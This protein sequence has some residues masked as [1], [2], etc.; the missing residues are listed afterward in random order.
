[1]LIFTSLFPNRAQPVHGIFIHQRVS[2]LGAREGN[3]VQVIAPVPYLPRWLRWT[4]WQTAVQVPAEEK[5]GGLVV[6]HPRYFLLPKVS[7]ILHGLLMFLGSWSLARRL[8]KQMDFDCIDAHYVYPDG[9]A[10]VLL[11]RRLGLPVVVSA[12]GTDINLFPTFRTIRPMIRWTLRHAAGI[13]AVSSSLRDAM[14]KLGAPAEKIAVIGNGV[15]VRRF[16]PVERGSARRALG[17]PETGPLIVSVGTLIPTKGHQ[18]LIEALAELAPRYP[19]LKAYVVGEGPY[20][21]QLEELAHAKG[22]QERVFLVGPKPN[23]D[24]KLWFSAADVSCLLSSREGWPNVLLETLAC[25]TP[26]VVTRVGGVPEV[27]CSPDLGVQVDPDV[28]SIAAGLELALRK[29]W[30]C[31]ALVRYAQARTWEVVGKE[32]ESYLG[33]VVDGLR[34]AKR[35]Y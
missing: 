24:L 1:V 17:L 21:A 3:T 31:E 25:G 20:R 9:F 5:I 29:N 4:R 23:E 8:K 18:S 13:V 15:D 30:S 11:G 27:I 33:S 19:N 32:V 14:V 2:H 28:T 6:Y 34:R 12:R 7:M 10:A 16:Q 22:V 26:V 35:E